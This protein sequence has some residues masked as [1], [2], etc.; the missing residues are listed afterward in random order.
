MLVAGVLKST[1]KL[2]SKLIFK[3]LFFSADGT[4]EV[5]SNLPP[6]QT[7]SHQ[8]ITPGGSGHLHQQAPAPIHSPSTKGISASQAA[9]PCFTCGNV[10]APEQGQGAEQAGGSRQ[11]WRR[12]SV[13]GRERKPWEKSPDSLGPRKPLATGETAGSLLVQ[14]KFMHASASQLAASVLEILGIWVEDGCDGNNKTWAFQ[15]IFTLGACEM[16]LTC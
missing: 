16:G 8:C 13:C 15:P 5:P 14:Q 3:I 1:I 10:T 2:C 11:G 9:L 12:F 6:Q 7:R 4:N